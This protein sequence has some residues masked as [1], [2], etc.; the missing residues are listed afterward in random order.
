MT[1]NELADLC[2]RFRDSLVC[3]NGEVHITV[4]L[5]RD[6]NSHVETTLEGWDLVDVMKDVYKG[7]VKRNDSE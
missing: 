5:T 3:L 1:L 2:A 4:I 7:A 6:E